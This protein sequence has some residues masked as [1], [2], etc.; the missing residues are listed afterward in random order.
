MK[1][2]II[3]KWGKKI[4]SINL[5]RNMLA[6]LLCATDMWLF[7]WKQ[8]LQC[9]TQNGLA[10]CIIREKKNLQRAFPPCYLSNSFQSA[11]VFSCII[12]ELTCC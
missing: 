2:Y 9:I 12:D 7:M 1:D 8:K 4:F 11:D 10:L 6:V 5:A 3:C